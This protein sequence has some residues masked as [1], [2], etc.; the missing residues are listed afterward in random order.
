MGFKF[1]MKITHLVNFQIFYIFLVLFTFADLV[2]AEVGHVSKYAGQQ[3]RQIK[4]LSSDDISELRRGG[5]WG[6]AKAAELNGMPGPAHILEME[7]KIKLTELQKN[8]IEKLFNTMRSQAIPLGEQLISLERQ[9][10][11][12]FSTGKIDQQSLEKLLKEIEQVRAKL[13]YVHLSTH[14]QTPRILTK[15]QISLYNE[16][17]GYGQDPCRH[18]PQGHD[19][20]MWRKHNGCE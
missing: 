9:L 12:N 3:N 20:Q 4:S 18:I 2:S 13:R 11:E 15:D 14:L 16:L 7:E 17:R 5:G 8:K 19:P 1:I 6:L 10:N